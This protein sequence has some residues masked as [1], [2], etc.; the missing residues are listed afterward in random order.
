[1]KE[2][3][4]EKERF[5]SK[6]SHDL[7]GSFTSILGFSDILGDPSENLNSEEVLDFTNR[8]GKQSHDT[9]ELLVNFVNWLKL[10]N[11]DYGLSPEKIEV[12]DIILD[13][14]NKLQKV[15]NEKNINF[16]TNAKTTDS[17]YLDFEIAD[18]IFSNTILF[19]TKI[20]SENSQIKINSVSCNEKYSC[21]EITASC[22]NENLSFLQNI[23]L[24][25]LN[26]EVSFPIIFAIKF[27]EQSGGE[28]NFSIDQ[29]NNFVIKLKLPRE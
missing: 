4:S 20:C 29:N 1:M 25:D 18:A 21:V 3:I 23:D 22:N 17:V 2:N 15:L 6:V 14:K 7:R 16:Q 13:V 9:F 19:I 10:E 12:L 26:N 8:I 11:Y 28:F 24:K 5:F 27:T